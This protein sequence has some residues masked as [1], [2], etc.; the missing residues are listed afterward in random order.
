[1]AVSRA[2]RTA[3]AFGVGVLALSGVAAAC[4]DDDSASTTTIESK[5]GGSS[6]A[7][8][9]D[10]SSGSDSSSSGSSGSSSEAAAAVEERGEPTVAAVEGPVTELKITDDVEGTGKEATPT[11]T[12]S[13][14]YVGAIAS[15]GEVFQSSWQMGGAVEFP[16][17]QVIQGWAE[18]IPGMKEGGRRTLVIPAAMAYGSTPPPGSGIP[19]DADLIFTVDLVAVA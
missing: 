18:G 15:T 12:V 7:S 13:A 4:G 5:G 16:L 8:T 3:A 14:Q 17:D 10:T 19:A 9:S 2:R 11:S 6:S 1:V